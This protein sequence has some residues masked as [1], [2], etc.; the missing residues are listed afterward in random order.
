MTGGQRGTN[1]RRVENKEEDGWELERKGRLQRWPYGGTVGHNDVVYGA[2]NLS[3][4]PFASFILAS[5]NSTVPSPASASVEGTNASP[6]ILSVVRY[7][8][9]LIQAGFKV[10]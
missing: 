10:K 8:A 3:V 2:V 7:Q 4:S 5:L 6:I 9:V 1:K